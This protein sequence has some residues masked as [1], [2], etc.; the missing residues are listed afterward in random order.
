MVEKRLDRQDSAYPDSLSRYKSDKYAD[1]G[2]VKEPDDKAIAGPAPD[3]VIVA[4]R[5]ARLYE[6][7]PKSFTTTD[8]TVE[9]DDATA[10]ATPSGGFGVSPRMAE[11]IKTE[12]PV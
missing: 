3:R 1:V 2:N 9:A 12:L 6:A 4:K 8:M 7:L 11:E 5:T 10:G